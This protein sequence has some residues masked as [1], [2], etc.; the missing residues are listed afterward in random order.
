MVFLN[1][2]D[3]VDT[4][5]VRQF[6]QFCLALYAF[7]F[8]FLFLSILFH[9]LIDIVANESIWSIDVVTW[10]SFEYTGSDAGI[11]SVGSDF[12]LNSKELSRM[13]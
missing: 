11:Y 7:G 9:L 8:W 6:S 12:A 1:K 13:V 2:A 5:Q 4:Q 3:Q 10:K